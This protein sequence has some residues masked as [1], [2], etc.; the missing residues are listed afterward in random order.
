MPQDKKM[1]NQLLLAKKMSDQ[2]NYVAKYNLM[3]KLLKDHPDEFYVDQDHPEY[4]GIVHA[5]TGF[6]MHLPRQATYGIEKKSKSEPTAEDLM[7]RPCCGSGCTNCP[8]SPKHKKGN[9]KVREELKKE[10]KIVKD[11]KSGKWILYTKD[12]SRILG[13]HEN[14]QDA[15]K[16]EY[17]IEKSMQKKASFIVPNSFIKSSTAGAIEAP[18]Q[19]AVII[20]GSPRYIENNPK[21]D[22][23]YEELAKILS[24]SGYETSYDAGEP[25]TIPDETA[26]LWI[27]HSRGQSR[28]QHAPESVKTLAVD[29]YE[30]RAKERREINRKLMEA[31]GAKSWAEWEDRPDP[32]DEHYQIT[33]DLR[34][35]IRE[36]IASKSEPVTKSSAINGTEE[37]VKASKSPV[38]GIKED[39][40]SKKASNSSDGLVKV[41]AKWDKVFKNLSPQAKLRITENALPGSEVPDLEIKNLLNS[42]R[43]ANDK[44]TPNYLRKYDGKALNIF[45]QGLKPKDNPSWYPVLKD[46]KASG[47]GEWEYPSII[48]KRT[49]DANFNPTNYKLANAWTYLPGAQGSGRYEGKTGELFTDIVHH[50]KAS[51]QANELKKAITAHEEGHAWT[52]NDPNSANLAIKSFINSAKKTLPDHISIGNDPKIPANWSFDSK[53]KILSE[54]AAHWRA[55][56]DNRNAIRFPLLKMKKQNPEILKK[57]DSDLPDNLS[58]Q[59]RRRILAVRSHLFQNYLID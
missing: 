16:Q 58:E 14:A 15:Y 5:P 26:Q 38:E 30:H 18:S 49:L 37:D 44:G 39:R 22:K 32:P 20:K 31:A 57:W 45:R 21:A 24:N 33:D 59:A 40:I 9:T 4:P 41:A 3:N 8:Y 11:K 29:Q 13:K 51:R 25:N 50:P 35:A 1:L 12:G 55:T 48:D 47:G 36:L 34:R 28:L 56:K 54:I 17:A 6:R 2:E 53:G 52:Y 7:K 23:F 27:A 43:T 19:K 10:A 46:Y 42:L